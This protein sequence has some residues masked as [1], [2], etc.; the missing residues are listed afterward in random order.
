MSMAIL[1]NLL[2]FRF[3]SVEYHV[4]HA[5]KDQAVEL[6]KC[7]YPDEMYHVHEEIYDDMRRQGGKGEDE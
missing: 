7:I 4:D 5:E 1:L 2:I 6:L 3:D